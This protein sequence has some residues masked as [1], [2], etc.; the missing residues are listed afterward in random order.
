MDDRENILKMLEQIKPVLF[1]KYPLKE[2]ALF[3]SV[4]R[5]ESSSESDIDILVD[6]Y[7][8]V[9]IEFIHLQIELEKYFNRKVD[10]VSKK[11]LKEGYLKEIEKELL[12]V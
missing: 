4:S 8:P 1:K 12:Y 11:G 5:Q 9:G 10:L 3:G 6:F 7:E 2:I